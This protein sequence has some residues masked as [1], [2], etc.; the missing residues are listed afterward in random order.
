LHQ[1]HRQDIEAEFVEKMKQEVVKNYGDGDTVRTNKDLG[2]MIN[3]RHVQRVARLIETS[4]VE[5]RIEHRIEHSIEHSIGG[6]S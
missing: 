2:R 3:S 5:H 4:Q 6:G 1:L